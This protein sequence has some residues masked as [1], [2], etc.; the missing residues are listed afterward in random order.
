MPR[1]SPA[2]GVSSP[3]IEILDLFPTQARRLSIAAL[4]ATARYGSTDRAAA[5]IGISGHQL[6]AAR[7]PRHLRHAVNVIDALAAYAGCSRADLLSGK[8]AL[9]TTTEPV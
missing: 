9:P 5:E 4:S 1:R 7:L 3:Q 8:T 2:R 6:A